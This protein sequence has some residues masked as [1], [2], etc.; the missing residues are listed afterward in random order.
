MTVSRTLAISLTLTQRY[1][2][3]EAAAE[4]ADA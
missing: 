4:T 1:L 2:S 3:M